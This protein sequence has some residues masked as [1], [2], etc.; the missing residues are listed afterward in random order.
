M[1]IPV[2]REQKRTKQ[3]RGERRHNEREKRERKIH[4]ES[5]SGGTGVDFHGPKPCSEFDPVGGS[6]LFRVPL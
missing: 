5:D 2:A 4:R 6:L 3:E 1:K